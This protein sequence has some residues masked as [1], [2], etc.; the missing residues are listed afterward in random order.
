MRADH[1]GAAG[2]KRTQNLVDRGG[3]GV[4]GG[5]DRGHHAERFRD[6]DDLDV[7]EAPQHAH[8][9]HRPDEFV[10]T[11]RGKLVLLDLVRHHAVARFLNR[12]PCQLLALRRDGRRHG[13]HDGIDALLR[14]L[15]NLR[16]G[17]FGA[18]RKGARLRHGGQ[19][20]IGGGA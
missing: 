8:R 19:I 14:Q 2:F 7:L 13:I 11:V 15:R 3:G 20:A 9:F 4:S 12:Q 18:S 17:L 6:F 1:D 5:D 10:N 16:L